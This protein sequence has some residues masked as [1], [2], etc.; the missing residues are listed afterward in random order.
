MEGL[1]PDQDVQLVIGLELR[2]LQLEARASA[3]ELDQLLHPDFVEFAA[4][5]RRWD[6]SQAIT[7]LTGGQP[8]GGPRRRTD[9]G[10]RIYFHQGTL[11]QIG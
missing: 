8:P 11:T 4:S 6:R 1:Q 10:W 3:G 2:L 7:S 9:A 5:G